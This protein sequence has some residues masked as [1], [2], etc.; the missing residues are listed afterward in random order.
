MLQLVLHDQPDGV[1]VEREA[2]VG[3]L[4]E[5][6]EVV[7]RALAH[8]GAERPGVAGAEQLEAAAVGARVGE[9]VVDVVQPLVGCLAARDL[10]DEPQLLVVRDVGDVPYERRLQRRELTHQL[11]IVERSEQRIRV[12]G[13]LREGAGECCLARADGLFER[14]HT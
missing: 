9:R 12:L 10:A 6:A 11:V 1:G 3:R 8:G 4:L 5:P 7:Q 14:C 13:G 2:L